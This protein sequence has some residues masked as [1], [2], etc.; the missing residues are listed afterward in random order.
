MI[1]LCNLTSGRHVSMGSEDDIAAVFASLLSGD[2]VGQKKCLFFYR[3]GIVRV[4]SEELCRYFNQVCI[5]S[6]LKW[7][8]CSG[9]QY[10]AL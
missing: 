1:H 8:K 4:C 10:F 7:P 5:V 2:N 3:I 9:D 6:R